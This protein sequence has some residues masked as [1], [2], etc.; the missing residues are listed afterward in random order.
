M[1]FYFCVVVIRCK[2]YAICLVESIGGVEKNYE[3]SSTF[4]MHGN[5]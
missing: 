4:V 5:I 3:M 1:L 2:I